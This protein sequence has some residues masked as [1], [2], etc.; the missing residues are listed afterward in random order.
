[1]PTVLFVEDDVL[2]RIATAEYLRESG[3]QVLE[4][5]DADEALAV[6]RTNNLIAVVLSDIR[7]PGE[8]DGVALAA[9]IKATWPHVPVVLTSSHLPDDV[10]VEPDS[11]IQKPYL[12]SRIVAVVEQLIGGKWKNG[13]AQANA[14]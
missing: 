9:I 1:M 6:L 10:E 7:M 2:I 5:A 11:F 14:S 3:H 4:A 8:H 13:P 12:Q